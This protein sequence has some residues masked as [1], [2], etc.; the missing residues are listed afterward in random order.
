MTGDEKK[1]HVGHCPNC[2]GKG[3]EKKSNGDEGLCSTCKGTGD[4][5]WPEPNWP[6]ENIMSEDD[7]PEE[8]DEGAE[9][10]E[11]EDNFE[12]KDEA[13]ELAN[14]IMGKVFGSDTLNKIKE[15]MER[16]KTIKEMS[17]KTKVRTSKCLRMV[18]DALDRVEC[19]G[20]PLTEVAKAA[21]VLEEIAKIVDSYPWDNPLQKMMVWQSCEKIFIQVSK[22]ECNCPSCRGERNHA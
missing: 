5:T 4:S 9:D 13:A 15:G 19:S 6:E 2:K 12:I 20:I 10:T 18:A 22:N 14:E 11:E 1:P 16:E 3:I 21:N 7:E 17:D 8:D